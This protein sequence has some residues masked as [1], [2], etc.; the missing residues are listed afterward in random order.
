[1]MD[2][3]AYGLLWNGSLIKLF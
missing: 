1:M 3:D 2:S